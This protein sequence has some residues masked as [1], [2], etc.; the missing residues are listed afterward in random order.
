MSSL[1]HLVE[2]ALVGGGVLL[3][4]GAALRRFW[5][6]RRDAAGGACS[7]CA[8]CGGCGSAPAARD[9]PKPIVLH[10]RARESSL[11]PGASMANPRLRPARE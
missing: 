4:L 8:G 5:P 1:Y 2:P 6:R 3:A 9:Q 10:R 11:P 7:S